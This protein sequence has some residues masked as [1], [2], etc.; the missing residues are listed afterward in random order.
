ML[1]EAGAVDTPSADGTTALMKACKS[2]NDK[3]AQL[4]LDHKSDINAVNR[5]GCTPL[6]LA[7]SN[8]VVSSQLPVIHVLLDATPP[9]NVNIRLDMGRTALFEAAAMYAPDIID[10]LIKAGADPRAADD[11]GCIA[12]MF[13]KYDVS[14]LPLLE[15]A[16]DTVNHR[17]IRGRTALH[18][19][20]AS[21]DKLKALSQL[22][23][24]LRKGEHPIDINAADDN[25]DSALHLAMAHVNLDAVK[26]LLENGA[27]VLGSGY[28][29][30]T[31]LMK[32]FLD[33][34]VVSSVYKGLDVM[35]S[36]PHDMLSVYDE[37]DDGD[38]WNQF[39]RDD[40]D[41]REEND[42][43]ICMRLRYVLDAIIG[44]Y[45]VGSGYD[46]DGG[47]RQTAAK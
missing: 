28:E 5:N 21:G 39:Y 4:L 8:Q 36:T 32:P 24:N 22:L 11:N 29:G 41:Y 37:A 20:S 7:I 17:D 45:C 27:E 13:A 35:S 31:V 3:V 1:L 23:E 9:A 12:L 38:Y 47:D 33:V 25:G 44:T 10:M 19:F 34:G 42:E 40:E 16:P 30:T 43:M 14:V 15:A 2:T 6:S 18:H 46:S 26:L